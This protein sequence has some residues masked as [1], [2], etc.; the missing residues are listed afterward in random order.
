MW[1]LEIFEIGEFEYLD[2]WDVASLTDLFR[3][4]RFFWLSVKEA[5]E[6]D[7]DDFSLCS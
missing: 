3:K 6:R 5:T 7:L 1:L 2:F 4:N